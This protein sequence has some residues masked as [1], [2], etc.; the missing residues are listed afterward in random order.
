MV[1]GVNMGKLVAMKIQIEG[2]V[3]KS[4]LADLQRRSRVFVVRLYREGFRN[5]AD[6]HAKSKPVT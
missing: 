1:S 3:V 6:I 2:Y 5:G 4:D